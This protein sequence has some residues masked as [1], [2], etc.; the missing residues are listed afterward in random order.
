MLAISMACLLLGGPLHQAQHASE[1]IGV[2]ALAFAGAASS[3][4]QP[5]HEETE[6]DLCLWCL[7]HAEQVPLVSIPAALSFH[8]EASAPPTVL[9]AGLP[10]R[11]CA[12]AA[13]PRGPPLA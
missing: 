1:P 2:A 10:A 13:D 12:L 3:S 5:D 6:V 8:A 7:F 11:H 9:P 4:A